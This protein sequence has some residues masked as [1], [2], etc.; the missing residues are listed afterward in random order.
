MV[1]NNDLSTVLAADF[2]LQ[3]PT[4]ESLKKASAHKLRKFFYAHQCRSEQKIQARIERIHS[5]LPLT[6]DSAIIAASSL[7]VEMLARQLKDL[8]PYIARYEKHIEQ[9]S[10][11]SILIGAGIPRI[12]PGAGEQLAPRLL[13]A[14]G[15]DR[16]RFPSAGEALTFFGVAPITERSGKTTW[17]HFRW[18]H[19]PQIPPPKLP[20]VCWSLPV[21]FCDWA[22]AFYEQQAR[23]AAKAIMLRCA[24][25]S[26]QKS[27]PHPVP[28][29]WKTRSTPTNPDLY[30]AALSRR[31]SPLATAVK[32][33]P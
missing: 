1:L 14:F 18:K 31:S 3:W 11:L 32:N 5:A 30:L 33:S 9:L 24:P 6:K 8:A 2:L 28:S 21:R 29:C 12:L 22:A 4:F 19:L 20:R 15:S 7:T 27:D 13:S 10:F 17:I 26:L 23:S 25:C 16:D